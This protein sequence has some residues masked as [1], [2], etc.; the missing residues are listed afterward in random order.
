MKGG[1]KPALWR[2][3]TGEHALLNAELDDQEAR[4]QK[5]LE[6]PIPAG[7]GGSNEGDAS[8]ALILRDPEELEQDRKFEAALAER[9]RQRAEARRARYEALWGKSEP[10]RSGA[11]RSI[12]GEEQQEA[13]PIES[14]GAYATYQTGQGE[15]EGENGNGDDTGAERDQQQ[16]NHRPRLIPMKALSSPLLG[17]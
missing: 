9:R 14:H 5:L 7:E 16:T 6:A 17:S 2:G 11:E 4:V 13:Y 3:A 1:M 15:G 8:T 10:E 12:E